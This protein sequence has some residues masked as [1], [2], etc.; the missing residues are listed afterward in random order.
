MSNNAR[1]RDP[2][3]TALVTVGIILV[4]ACLIGVGS[5]VM[6]SQGCA[7]AIK[8]WQ[9]DYAGGLPR[10]VTVYDYEGDVIAQYEGRIDVVTNSDGASEVYFDLNGRRII[11][12]GGIVITEELS[13]DELGTSLGQLATPQP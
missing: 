3:K 7:R 13:D 12:D 1:P 2:K 6:G 4:L 8:S 10:R 5:C 11:I 9:S